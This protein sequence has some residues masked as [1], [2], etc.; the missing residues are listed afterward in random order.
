MADLSVSSPLAGSD[1]PFSVPGL[2]VREVDFVQMV[3]VAPLADADLSPI[4]DFGGLPEVGRWSAGDAGEVF[5]AGYWH[6]FVR[7]AGVAGL[8]LKGAA[9]TD[10]SDGWAGMRLE[11]ALTREV[12]ARLCPLDLRLSAFG[13]GDVARTEFAHMMSIVIARSDGLDVFVMRSFAK[14]AVH[15]LKDAALSVA[16]QV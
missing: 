6:W 14:T 7:G 10:Q 2:A 1:L 3:S 4:A 12:V 8:K 15:H 16:A 13:Q 11:G 9:I 5:W